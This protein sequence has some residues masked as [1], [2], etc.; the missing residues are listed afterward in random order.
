MDGENL[1]AYAFPLDIVCADAMNGAANKSASV[2][3]AI[4]F[5][6]ILFVY[7]MQSYKV[8][9]LLHTKHIKDVMNGG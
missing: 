1:P 2:A 3:A 9:L 4:T 5:F 8:L 7:L 6:V